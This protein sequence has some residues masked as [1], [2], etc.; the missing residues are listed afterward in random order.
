MKPP[1]IAA[2]ASLLII[3][4]A[5]AGCAPTSYISKPINSREFVRVG[6]VVLH[7]D[8]LE[9][10]PVRTPDFLG[11]GQD[12]GFS[13]LSYVGLN[14]AMQPV[15]RRRD[16][17]IVATAGPSQPEVLHRLAEVTSEFAL[18]YSKGRL[19]V[20]RNHNIE[21]I[22]ANHAGVTFTVQ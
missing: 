18:D 19:I 16:V 21:I 12:K 11:N 8:A 9:D 4:I 17:D 1:I 13:E 22:E 20:M 7:V 5:L 2:A 3:A 6:E 10:W 14:H 15:F